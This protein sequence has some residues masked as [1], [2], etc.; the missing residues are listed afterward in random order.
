MASCCSSTV[1]PVEKHPTCSAV[2]LKKKKETKEKRPPMTT[3][4]KAISL[5]F[6]IFKFIISPI[7]LDNGFHGIEG[8]LAAIVISIGLTK[9]CHVSHKL[10][11]SVYMKGVQENSVFT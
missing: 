3:D 2:V 11:V 9:C 7:S 10:I 6:F 1:P 8:M 4:G 5:P